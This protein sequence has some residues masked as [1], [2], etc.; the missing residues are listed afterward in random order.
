VIKVI[1]NL[2]KRNTWAVA[3][4]LVIN[5]IWW[6]FEALTATEEGRPKESV[7]MLLF[8]IL[9]ISIAMT[10]ISDKSGTGPK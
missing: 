1:L 10:V 3:I 6:V 9:C 5:G 4:A 7:L 2:I 8:G